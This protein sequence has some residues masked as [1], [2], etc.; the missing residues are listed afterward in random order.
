LQDAAGLTGLQLAVLD[1]LWDEGEATA[2]GVWSRMTLDR[3]LALTTV[4]TILSRL[5][6]KELLEHRREGRRFVYRA[7]VSR[8]DVRSSKIRNLT[9]TLFDGDPAQLVEHV[10]DVS[11]IDRTGAR[12]IRD[13]LDT[14][15]AS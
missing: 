11:A 14:L 7:R 6:R 8:R 1:V 5:T 12:R 15:I 4:S 13:L 9:E 3:P 10:F 2:Q